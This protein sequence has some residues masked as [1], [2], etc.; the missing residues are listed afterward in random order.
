M[1]VVFLGSI[2]LLLQF[3]RKSDKHPRSWAYGINN[4]HEDTTIRVTNP[5]YIIFHI[6]VRTKHIPSCIWLQRGGCM[7]YVCRS[8]Y[9]PSS[10]WLRCLVLVKRYG[11]G[12][13]LPT[14]VLVIQFHISAHTSSSVFPNFSYMFKNRRRNSSQSALVHIYIPVLKTTSWADNQARIENRDS[15]WIYLRKKTFLRFGRTF[16]SLCDD[17]IFSGRSA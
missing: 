17:S 11:T 7:S 15:M 12:I 3:Y 6:I 8:T 10:C 9:N 16:Q 14:Y 13:V 4:L 2:Y 1:R 5:Y